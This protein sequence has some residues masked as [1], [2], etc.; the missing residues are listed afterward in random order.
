MNIGVNH[1]KKLLFFCLGLLIASSFCMKWMEGAFRIDGTSFS[2]MDL[3]LF[4]SKEKLVAVLKG[5]SEHTRAI[6]RYHLYFDFVF[7]AGIFPVAAAL[8]MIARERLQSKSTRRLLF[9]LAAL[10]TL[11][12]LADIRED[13]YLLKWIELPVIGAEFEFYHFVVVTKFIIVLAGL[14]T[15]ITVL[16]IKRKRK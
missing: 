11:A 5:I 4:Y 12:W 1:W 10:Q 2:I 9:V 16:L 7:M 6:L 8:C 3:E 14:I 15:G 13:M